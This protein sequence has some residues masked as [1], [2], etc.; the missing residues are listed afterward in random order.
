[1]GSD[2]NREYIDTSDHLHV[3]LPS[4]WDDSPARDGWTPFFVNINMDHPIQKVVI[5]ERAAA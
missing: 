4:W 5:Y 2:R 1:M 3:P